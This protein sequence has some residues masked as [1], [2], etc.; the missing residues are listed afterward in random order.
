M[1]THLIRNYRSADRE[2]YV[3]FHVE[4]ES[5]C[6]CGDTFFLAS[7]KGESP[8]PIEFSEDD[9]FLTEEQGRIV[10][11]CRV[12]PEPAI[13][14]AVLMLLIEPG[15]LDTGAA[16]EL[17]RSA[18][19]RADDLELAKVHADLREDNSAARDLFAGL[20]FR[21]VRRYAEMALEL[22]SA[23]IPESKHEELSHRPL[24]PG[25]EAEFTE[26]QNRAFDGSWGFCPNTTTE[27]VQQLNAPGFGHDGVI[28]SYQGEKAVGYCW[29]SEVQESAPASDK[30]IG[31]IHMMGIA[32][33][34]RGRG[35]GEYV[36]WSGLKHLAGKGIQTVELTM[37][38]DNEAARSLYERAGFTP[39]TALIWYEKKLR[40][41]SGRSAIKNR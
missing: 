4:A 6:R 16:A 25:C 12:V 10:G 15:S 28:I 9:V 24:E 5:I 18:L 37:D 39:K 8:T 3:R 7:L 2:R 13:D 26:L 1:N 30:P 22:D 38:D 19:T 14:R 34:F 20:G 27:I 31:R 41:R 29:T 11:A 23:S 32:P 33:E 40:S 35:F 17:L 36:L 21:P